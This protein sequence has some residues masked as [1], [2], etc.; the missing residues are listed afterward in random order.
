MF[1]KIEQYVSALEGCEEGEEEQS[2]RK[3][4][5]PVTAQRADRYR[6]LLL[7]IPSYSFIADPCIVDYTGP[8]RLQ[9]HQ[10]KEETNSGFRHCSQSILKG[11]S[12]H[13]QKAGLPRGL[14]LPLA[15]KSSRTF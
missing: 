10:E 1:G 2:E 13:R 8:G 11:E 3:P 7:E 5:F 9:I 15:D 4:V 12:V 14:C 6:V